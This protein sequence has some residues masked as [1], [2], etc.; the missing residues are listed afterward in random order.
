MTPI[1]TV[2]ETNSTMMNGIAVLQW[3]SVRCCSFTML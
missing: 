3:W 2:M 1:I